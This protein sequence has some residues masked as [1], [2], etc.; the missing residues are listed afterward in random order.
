MTVIF[1]RRGGDDLEQ[2]HSIWEKTVRASPDI[3][4]MTFCPVTDLLDGITGK[5]HLTRAIALYLECKGTSI[6]TRMM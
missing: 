6:L 1:R 2:N 5:E 3:I 4:E